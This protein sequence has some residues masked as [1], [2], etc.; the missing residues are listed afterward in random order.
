MQLTLM[1]VHAHPD[2][3]VISTGGVLAR[4]AAEGVRT[5]LVTCT[6]GEQGDGPDGTKPDQDGHD[7]AEVVR[8]RLEE[9]RASA[10]HLGIGHVELLGFRDSGMPGWEANHHPEAFSN[11][12]VAYATARLARLLEQYRPDVVVTHDENGGAGHPDHILAHRITLEASR[13]TGIPRKVY[14]MA[15]PRGALQDLFQQLKDAGIDLGFEPPDDIG[16]PDE[17]VTATVDVS[18]HVKS[19]CKALEA[20]TSQGENMFLLWL[21]RDVRHRVLAKEYFTLRYG[22]TGSV[23]HEDDLFAGLR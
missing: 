11:I 6:D 5:V 3:E 16:T 1:A 4:Y 13:S 10:G 14:E 21:P 17:D 23:G 12:P 18:P 8:R 22:D 15:L 7:E 2:D 20:Y 9:L 19:K